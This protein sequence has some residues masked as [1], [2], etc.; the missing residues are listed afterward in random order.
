[1]KNKGIDSNDQADFKKATDALDDYISKLD[2]YPVLS[3][4]EEHN[5]FVHLQEN[6]DEDARL[7]IIYS[8]LRLVVKIAKIYPTNILSLID[9]IQEGNL[10]LIKAVSGFDYQLGN[11]FST[12]ANYLIK[13]SIINALNEKSRSVRL[14]NN[15]INALRKI[16]EAQRSYLEANG[17]EPNSEELSV[18]MNH[19]YTPDKI[20]EYI[21]MD[22]EPVNLDDKINDGDSEIRDLIGDQN[23]ITP[24][25][26]SAMQFLNEDFK[27]AFKS[28]KPKEKN[29]IIYL[30]GFSDGE[31][32]SLADAAKQFGMSREG[33]RS[34]QNTA[35]KKLRKFFE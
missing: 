30:Y 11:R 17:V 29:V 32:H 21:D 23:G 15:I 6:Q 4:E 8:N 7:H 28:L 24:S 35:L 31:S 33:V 27:E 22:R 34:I 5:L 18:Y 16:R 26:F 20:R 10:G 9:L 3:K 1:M 25:K 14:P 19:L 12:Y 13:E 2:N